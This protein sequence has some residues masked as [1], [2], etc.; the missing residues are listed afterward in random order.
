[1]M[2]YLLIFFIVTVLVFQWRSSRAD[3][4]TKTQAKAKAPPPQKPG[5][6]AANAPQ[7]MIACTECGL[8]VPAVDAVQGSRGAY[9]S[10][11]HRRLQEP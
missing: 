7:A 3:A 5:A 8:H 11:A 1:M 6:Q 2:K 4:K 10:A 9:C